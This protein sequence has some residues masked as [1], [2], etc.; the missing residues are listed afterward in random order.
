V[1][2]LPGRSALRAVAQHALGCLHVE[3]ERSAG[4]H[5][6]EAALARLLLDCAA[7][8]PRGQ[9]YTATAQAWVTEVE[10]WADD[11][12]E[13]KARTAAAGLALL[14][15]VLPEKN[16]LATFAG[17]A[18]AAYDAMHGPWELRLAIAE[19]LLRSLAERLSQR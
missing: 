9:V 17:A 18:L 3:G 12:I 11:E 6:A 10:R 19:P 8:A 5:T 4:A 13:K 2:A 14:R 7:D 15:E 1:S 16:E